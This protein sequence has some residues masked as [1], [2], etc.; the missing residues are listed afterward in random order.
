MR[1]STVEGDP[2]YLDP[3]TH[4]IEVYLNGVEVSEVVTADE[5]LGVVVRAVTDSDGNIVVDYERSCVVYETLQ[6]NVK[7]V[8]KE[9]L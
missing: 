9:L 8:F 5:E 2:G 3:I 4:V 7:I 6:G 1:V